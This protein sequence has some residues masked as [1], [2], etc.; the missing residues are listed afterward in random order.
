MNWIPEKS[1]YIINDEW[2]KLR[3]DTCRMP[4]G[5]I[6][7]PY[8][9]IEH[10]NW[11]NV[12]AITNEQKVVMV[13]QYRHGIGEVVTE[14]PA[15]CIDIEDKSASATIRRELLEETGYTADEFILTGKMP[16]NTSNHNNMTYSYLALN[17]QYKQ[18]PKPDATEQLKVHLLTFDEVY[19]LIEQG[20]LQALHTASFLLAMRHLAHSSPNFAL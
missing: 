12:V 5:T 2:I 15:G 4:D 8:Y 9:V 18:L 7:D 16:L 17:A 10:S 14:L 11:V 1:H 19:Q 20:K 6:L 3:S 13:Q